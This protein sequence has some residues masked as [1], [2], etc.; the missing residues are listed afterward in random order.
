MEEKKLYFKVYQ[1]INNIEGGHYVDTLE[2]INQSFV[3]WIEDH[4]DTGEL[5]PCI[6]PVLMTDKEY[7]KLP[8]FDGF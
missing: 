1:D 4:N 6:E 3:P 8:E 5:F 7:S 2:N